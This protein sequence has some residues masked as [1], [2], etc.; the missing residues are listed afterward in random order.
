MTKFDA[1]TEATADSGKLSK[2]FA[3]FTAF[4]FLLPAALAVFSQAANIVA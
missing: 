3:V 1:I 2:F 4:S